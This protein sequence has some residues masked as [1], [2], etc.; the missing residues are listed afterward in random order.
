MRRHRKRKKCRKLF[1]VFKD[2]MNWY[3]DL[4]L[5]SANHPHKDI[6]DQ[7]EAFYSKLSARAISLV[8]KMHEPNKPM[9][10][11]VIIMSVVLK[12]I[13][14]SPNLITVIGLSFLTVFLYAVMTD[15]VG[16][17]IAS[18]FG[19]AAKFTTLKEK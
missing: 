15:N 4:S 19:V 18:I 10:K 17:A 14:A 2:K 1:N 16:M 11:D 8:C 12:K 9:I 7:K 3:R 6:Y 13:S 5:C